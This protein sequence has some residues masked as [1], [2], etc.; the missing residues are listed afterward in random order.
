[1]LLFEYGIC[2][3]SIK[4]LSSCNNN[5][6]ISLIAITH[7]MKWCR[8]KQVCFGTSKNIDFKQNTS[9]VLEALINVAC[10]NK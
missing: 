8:K 3:L 5:V 7:E 6:P 1:M 9:S 10:V 4:L 2:Q